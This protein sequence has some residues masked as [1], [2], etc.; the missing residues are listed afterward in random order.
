M[1]EFDDTIQTSDKDSSDDDTASS[2]TGHDADVE[3]DGEGDEGDLDFELNQTQTG[4]FRAVQRAIESLYAQRYERA[5]NELP[6][7]PSYLYHVLHTLKDRRPDLFRQELRVSPKTFDT[8]VSK[9]ET[10]PVFTNN[11]QNEQIAIEEQLAITLFRFGH[12]GNAASLQ[13]VANWAGVGKGTVTLITRRVM[14]AILRRR[15]MSEAVRMPTAMEKEEA[16]VWVEAHSCKAWKDG[17]CFVDGTLVPLY[18]RPFWYGES[19]FDRKCNYSLN[20][21]ASQN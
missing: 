11:S 2:D 5:R 21:Q 9:I 3:L 14:T 7:G 10:D 20:V 1:I 19:Y 13:R 18:D 6:R 16:K 12:D 8:F 15:F 4:R 17:W